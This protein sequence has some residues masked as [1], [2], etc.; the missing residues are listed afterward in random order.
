MQREMWREFER[1]RDKRSQR[2]IRERQVEG[3]GRE[4]EI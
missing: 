3:R 2:D 1:K 4:R